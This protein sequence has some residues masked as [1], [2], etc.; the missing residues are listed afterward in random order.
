MM[1]R[2]VVI[3][4]D[5][6]KIGYYFEGKNLIDINCYEEDEILGNVYIG[7][8]SNILNNINAAFVDVSPELSCYLSLED[9]TGKENLKIGSLIPVQISKDS[10]KTKQPSVT[11][12][13]SLTGK[14]VVIHTDN[15]LGVSSKIKDNETRE[16]LKDIFADALKSFDIIKK[17]RDI[18]YGA[19]IRTAAADEANEA[20]KDEMIT[21]LTRLDDMLYSAR[22]LKAYSKIY[23]NVPAYIKSMNEYAGR[24]DT[25]V[26]T[27]EK[28]IYEEY[29]GYYNEADIRL[30]NDEMVS[31]S[32]LYNLK[33]LTDKALNKKAYLNSGAYLVIEVT[34]AMTVIDVNSGKAIR[35]NNTEEYIYKINNEAAKEIAR[36]IRLRN[37]SGIIVVDFISMK[38]NEYN[39]SLLEALSNYVL[40][41]SIPAKVVDITKLGLVELTRKK[42]RK[43]LHEM[44]H[45]IKY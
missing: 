32:N 28:D 42:V 33:S 15:L 7:R 1:N 10:I 9:Y 17:C 3:K 27:D 12:D 35:G 19:V 45:L 34:E 14:N 36:Q 2:F 13:I 41:D 40:T 18:S 6:V 30:Y 24:E 38:N 23:V 44:A 29:A 43:P 8:V 4:K 25:E 11:T 31:L 16:R 22:Y 5:K 39:K 21:L 20:I 26:V 37:L